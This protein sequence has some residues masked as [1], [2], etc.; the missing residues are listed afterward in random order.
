MEG[1]VRHS[2]SMLPRTMELI[3][4]LDIPPTEQPKSSTPKRDRKGKKMTPLALGANVSLLPTVEDALRLAWNLSWNRV[5]GELASY[6]MAA[7]GRIRYKSHDLE[8][9]V[10]LMSASELANLIAELKNKLEERDVEFGSARSSIDDYQERLAKTNNTSQLRDFE[11]NSL[12]AKVFELKRQVS[13][14]KSDLSI[15]DTVTL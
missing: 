15:A 5:L 10:Q 6:I 13:E 8:A 12:R 4:S 1:P 11:L 7:L 14:L 9:Q 3:D 2:G